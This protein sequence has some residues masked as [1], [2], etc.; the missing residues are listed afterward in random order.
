[1]VMDRGSA[2]TV[3]ASSNVMPCLRM[4]ETALYES[5]PNFNVIFPGY[6]F[7]C[8]F[9]GSAWEPF[10]DWGERCEPQH[11]PGRIDVSDTHVGVRS[12]PPY[13]LPFPARKQETPR[14]RSQA[15]RVGWAKA[16]SPV[17]HFAGGRF[18][19]SGAP[20]FAFGIAVRSSGTKGKRSF[21][22]LLLAR[23]TMTAISKLD[24]FCW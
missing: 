7:L 10:P 3:L 12:S 24:R 5:H 4:F 15:A 20:G 14:Q 16:P 9:P 13:A 18:K 1:M 22:L 2:K 21:T 17:G 8:W 23:S 19:T 6:V 11:K